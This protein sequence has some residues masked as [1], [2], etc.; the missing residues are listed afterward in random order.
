MGFL[1]IISLN[2]PFDVPEKSEIEIKEL[3]KNK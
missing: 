2:N 3:I 1:N